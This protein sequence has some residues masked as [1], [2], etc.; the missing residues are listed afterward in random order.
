MLNFH[1]F[2]PGK[3]ERLYDIDTTALTDSIYLTTGYPNEI[4]TSYGSKMFNALETSVY[5]EDKFNITKKLSINAG[6][7]LSSYVTT[8]TN[9]YSFQPRLILNY[10]LGSLSSV[11]FSYALMKQYMHMLTGSNANM[12]TDIWMPAT[13][14]VLPEKSMQITGGYV[15]NFDQLNLEFSIEG[16][17]KTLSNL[18]EYKSGESLTTGTKLWTEKI[19]KEGSGKIYGIEFLIRKDMGKLNGWIGYTWSKNKRQFSGIDQNVAFYYKFDRRHDF[20]IVANYELKENINI[21]ANWIIQSGIWI[22]LGSAKYDAMV[23]NNSNDIADRQELIYA[24]DRYRHGLIE[25]AFDNAYI[26]GTRNNYQLP[27]YHKLDLSVT[28]TKQKKHGTRDWIISI[29]NVYNQKNAYRVYYKVEKGKISLYK[30][31]LFPIIPSISYKYN[32]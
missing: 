11:K 26:Y 1:K 30:F 20:S 13:R 32:F 28:F 2:N 3:I 25:Y 5:F 22:T 8:D 31:T 14:D 15:R 9:F 29:Y 10:E 7:H 27:A 21:S 12:P 18:I 17:Y 23:F 24:S 6:F 4:D 16:F 19:E